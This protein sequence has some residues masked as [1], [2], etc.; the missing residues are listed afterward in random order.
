[1]CRADTHAI[2]KQT[3][4]H[5]DQ[6]IFKRTH[7]YTED[8]FMKKERVCVWGGAASQCLI[9]WR[10]KMKQPS[11]QV[12]DTGCLFSYHLGDK[13]LESTREEIRTQILR[14]T[15]NMQSNSTHIALDLNH[16]LKPRR[17]LRKKYKCGMRSMLL[18]FCSLP[19]YLFT[20]SNANYNS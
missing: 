12:K 9:L 6:V 15:L 19:C 8:C 11:A 7:T 17:S 5:T 4:T 16:D 13:S 10:K 20:P 1:M 14:V 18:Q 3:H 2:F